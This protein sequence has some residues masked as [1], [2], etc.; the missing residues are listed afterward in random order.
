V[1]LGEDLASPTPG[2][3][4]IQLKFHELNSP[5]TNTELTTPHK[6]DLHQVLERRYFS[7]IWV[8]QE[9]VLSR[10]IAMRIGD[11]E[12]WADALTSSH[13]KS[14]HAG[15]NWDDTSAPWA[16]HMAQRSFQQRDI[17]EIL[18]VTSKS[19]ASDPRDRIFGIHGLVSD[20][21]SQLALRPNYSLSCLHVFLSVFAHSLINLRHPELLLNAS[22]IS[23]WDSYP[24]WV[25][26]WTSDASS[27][28]FKGPAL[29]REK[30]RSWA[31]NWRQSVASSVLRSKNKKLALQVS[32]ALRR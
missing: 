18:K 30:L 31:E 7:R 4:P 19:K 11:V 12:L 28:I 16:E 5:I 15:W 6:T 1:Y 26:N 23:A 17:Y 21:K 32:A 27:W 13:L 10:Q 25:P 29:W 9:L 3:H 20:D 14:F 24:S 2:R 22:G 8:I